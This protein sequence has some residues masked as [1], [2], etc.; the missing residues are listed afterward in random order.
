MLVQAD[1][2]QAA[3]QAQEAER[4][5]QLSLIWQNNGHMYELIAL[6][7]YIAVTGIVC[8]VLAKLGYMD[9]PPENPNS[10]IILWGLGCGAVFFGQMIWGTLFGGLLALM[11][12]GAFDK[13]LK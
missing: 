12:I 1:A 10:G 5:L 9:V 11:A 3:R 4:E 6:I 13:K 8:A 2:D 7:A